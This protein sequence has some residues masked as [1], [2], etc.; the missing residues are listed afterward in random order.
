MKS[1]IFESRRITCWKKKRKNGTCVHALCRLKASEI[2]EHNN[3][4]PRDNKRVATK[5]RS[6]HRGNCL[7]RGT[8]KEE[9]WLNREGSENPAVILARGKPGQRPG[10]SSSSSSSTE[11]LQRMPG[12]AQERPRAQRL[13]DIEPQTAKVSKSRY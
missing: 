2:Y 4:S 1:F 6:E 13:T 10:S 5:T 9:E 12:P 8:W 11:R 7:R 3:I